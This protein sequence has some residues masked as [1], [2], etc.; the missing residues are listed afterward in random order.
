MK[1]LLTYEQQTDLLRQRGLRV[2]D[3][4]ACVEFLSQVGYYRLSG[5]FRYWQKDPAYGDNTF[6]DGAD[7]GVIRDL[8]LAEERLA[9]ECMRSL[10]QVEVMLRVRFSHAYAKNVAVQG[11]LSSGMGLTAPTSETHTPAQEYVRRDLDQ[12]KEAFIGRSRMEAGKGAF[13]DNRYADLYAWAAVEVLSVGTLSRCIAASRDSGVLGELAQALGIEQ[14]TFASKVKSL[15][16]LR[17]RIAHHAKIW[18]HSVIDAPGLGRARG[19]IKK[20]HGG[21]DD[22][23][24]YGV[25]AVLDQLLLKS[26]LHEGWLDEVVDPLL[27]ENPLL[28]RGIRHP[29]RYG[30]ADLSA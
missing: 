18:N 1:L 25:L 27:A 4:P 29:R 21:F 13:T 12:S 3:E 11:G 9:V 17:N 16:Y 14:A 26:G 28:D 15:V 5:Y 19:R 8:Y 22:R 2:E 7:F 10:R 6:V 20:R 30:E 24:I 23:S